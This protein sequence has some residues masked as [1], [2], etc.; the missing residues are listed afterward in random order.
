MA[1]KSNLGIAF[2]TGPNTATAGRGKS[3]HVVE[4]KTRAKHVIADPSH[5]MRVGKLST[6][7]Q[8]RLR[9]L[10]SKEADR[11]RSNAGEGGRQ[12]GRT[13]IKE[14]TWWKK[15]TAV[16]K[17]FINTQLKPITRS[18]KAVRK[19]PVKGRA[20]RKAVALY[21]DFHGENPKHVDDYDVD[22]P[23]VALQVGKVSGI[24][25]KARFEGKMQEFLHEFSGKSQPILAA[26][27]DGRQLLLLGGDYKFTERGIV[28]G[29]Y[30]IE[31]N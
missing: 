21:R 31:R 13:N 19:N 17:K 28:D 26:S 1:R 25:Y 23:E 16:E 9:I 15:L 30:S 20:Y 12:R 24:M 14:F 8:A 11:R 7:Q 27:A 6:A 5:T 4:Q 22:L 3:R 2:K 18:R 10:A 29:S